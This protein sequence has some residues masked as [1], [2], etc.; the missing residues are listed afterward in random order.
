VRFGP[1]ASAALMSI[2]GAILLG[3]GFVQVGAHTNV[4]LVAL[5]TLT[6]IAGYAFSAHSHRPH[7]VQPA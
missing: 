1:L 2:I 6:A 5:L 3:Q 4:I 7:A